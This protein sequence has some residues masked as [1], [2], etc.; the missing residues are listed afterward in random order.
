MC[1]WITKTDGGDMRRWLS[2]QAICWSRGLPIC[3]DR[4]AYCVLSGVQRNAIGRLSAIILPRATAWKLSTWYHR[5]LQ[6]NTT[7]Y[8]GTWAVVTLGADVLG[9]RRVFETR[10]GRANGQFC[11]SDGA[12]VFVCPIQGERSVL[13]QAIIGPASGCTP[14]HEHRRHFRACVTRLLLW[15]VSRRTTF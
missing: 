9:L 12:A 1:S 14:R 2:G 15:C 3:R 8:H 5:A 13:Y 11:R 6:A 10:I 4:F 7:K